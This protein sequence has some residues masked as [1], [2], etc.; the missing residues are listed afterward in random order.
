MN[1]IVE[2]SVPIDAANDVAGF[3]NDNPYQMPSKERLNR[4]IK[5]RTVLKCESRK[6]G[7]AWM[8]YE[9]TGELWSGR[10]RRKEIY[11]YARDYV[12][13]VI[14]RYI[15]RYKFIHPKKSLDFLIK[16]MN[17]DV[18]GD[19]SRNFSWH[20]SY[21]RTAME[22]VFP[23]QS[24]GKYCK[25]EFFTHQKCP[26]CGG[27]LEKIY[28]ENI[29]SPEP[30]DLD[31][32]CG[33]I[34]NQSWYPGLWFDKDGKVGVSTYSCC[35]KLCKEIESFLNGGHSLFNLAKQHGIKPNRQLSK[36]KYLSLED[37]YA[38]AAADLLD[39]QA[40]YLERIDSVGGA[41]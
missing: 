22:K 13:K 41:K 19:W 15:G 32:R 9:L 14:T 30:F 33:K 18:W 21:S 12:E 39:F 6:H 5:N 34:L 36:Y 1:M 24:D 10:E 31:M 35:S 3:R 27:A 25:V 26:R 28:S 16:V 7:A 23:Y 17:R 8:Y 29:R 38:Q 4:F 20:G 11:Q 40:R 37:K 2:I